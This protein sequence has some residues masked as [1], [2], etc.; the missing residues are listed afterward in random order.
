MSVAQ[1]AASM[2][3]VPPTEIPRA[4][5]RALVK[6]STVL[7]AKGAM[8]ARSTR[9]PVDPEPRAPALVAR[10]SPPDKDYNK[11][12]DFFVRNGLFGDYFLLLAVIHFITKSTY[13]SLPHAG[14]QHMR[15]L[16]KWKNYS[17]V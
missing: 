13:M 9:L 1:T 6:A 14:E 17:P 15:K 5:A 4:S 7:L 16:T 8:V 12:C 10:L 2:A 3:T 11:A